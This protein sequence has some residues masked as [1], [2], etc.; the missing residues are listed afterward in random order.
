MIVRYE[1]QHPI[2]IPVEIVILFA[3]IL[4]S[5]GAWEDAISLFYVNKRLRKLF[6][7]NTLMPDF[8][9]PLHFEGKA[10][11]VTVKF[12]SIKFSLLANLKVS[13][14]KSQTQGRYFRKYGIET[15]KPMQLSLANLKRLRDEREITA[16]QLDEADI[17]W[18]KTS[19]L[20]MFFGFLSIGCHALYCG[21]N[22]DFTY[23]DIFR[24]VCYAFLL[25][26]LSNSLGLFRI[27]LIHQIYHDLH[28]K[29][30][31]TA[32]TINHYFNHRRQLLG[33]HRL[34]LYEHLASVKAAEWNDNQ[35]SHKVSKQKKPQSSRFF[36]TANKMSV[37]GS[38]VT[39]LKMAEFMS[40]I[41]KK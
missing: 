3:K 40:K 9:F 34:D 32:D 16:K 18:N 35:T 38:H 13:H 8:T 23:A 41:R 21:V 14:S 6:Q 28:V 4:L 20:L 36:S 7:S 11:P 17:L 5:E 29:H 1:D 31:E 19:E 26:P 12:D 37:A 33:K 27:L 39:D 10:E 15:A 30:H 25:A 24:I 2:S 22:S